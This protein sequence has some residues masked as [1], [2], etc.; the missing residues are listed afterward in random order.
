M[1][2]DGTHAQLAAEEGSEYQKMVAEHQRT[3][4]KEQVATQNVA[5]VDASMQKLEELAKEPEPATGGLKRQTTLK[6][7]KLS[8]KDVKGMDAESAKMIVEAENLR[9][10][11]E[12]KL[13]E[14]LDDLIDPKK[15]DAAF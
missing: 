8:V 7:E 6:T 11:F 13:N 2:Q 1:V 14:D 4:D 12:D 5:D 3:Q 15:M 10:A 9:T